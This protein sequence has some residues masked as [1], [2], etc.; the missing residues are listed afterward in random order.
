MSAAGA[1]GVHPIM[2]QFF[3]VSCPNCQHHLK[4]QDDFINRRVSCKFCQYVFRPR[5]EELQDYGARTT[6][7]PGLAGEAEPTGRRVAELEAEVQQ[8]RAELGARTAEYAEAIWQ[9]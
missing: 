8:S 9:A 6:P 7:P 5:L 3:R 4:I 1:W 2:A